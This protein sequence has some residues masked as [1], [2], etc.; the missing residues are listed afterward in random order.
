MLLFACPACGAEVKFKNRT[1]LFNVCSFCTSMLVRTDV[2]LESIGKMAALLPDMSLLQ[3]GTRGR[4][5]G[6]LFEVIGKHRLQWEDGAWNEWYVLFD[7]GRTGWLAEAQGFFMM[8]FLSDYTV[9][10]SSANELKPGQELNLGKETFV[11]EDIKSAKSLGAI[12]EL[13]VQTFQGKNTISVDLSGPNETFASLDFSGSVATVY[14]GQYVD[15]DEF[16]FDNLKE[17]D[18]W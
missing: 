3:I 8:S 11:V 6:K 2:D 12:G 10:V 14:L 4:L 15:F 13:P 16:K 7:D 5:K 9:N 1:S 17:L 18:G